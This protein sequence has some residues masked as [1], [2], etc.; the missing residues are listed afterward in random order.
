MSKLYRPVGLYEM[1]LIIE[2]GCTNFPER[3]PEQPYFYPVLNRGYADRI[4]LKWNTVDAKS[5]YAGYITE[6]HVNDEYI[7]KFQKHIVG[8]RVH[9][10]LWIS[11]EELLNFNKNIE[12]KIKIIDAYYGKQYKG[13]EPLPTFLK[14]KRVQEQL[15]ILSKLRLYNVMD[16]RCEVAAQWKTIILNIIFWIKSNY[17]DNITKMEEKQMNT[18]KD[19]YSVLVD[20]NR[21]YILCFENL[22][23]WG[24]DDE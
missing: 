9:E 14:N 3:F 15:I 2:S 17:N 10:E 13:I 5:G 16:F 18:I 12:G 4:A 23:N 24:V 6:F 22:I 8:T 7:N 1:K 20:N 11:A 19:I 21:D